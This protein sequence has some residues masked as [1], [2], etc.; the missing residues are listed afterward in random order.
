MESR[1]LPRRFASLVLK[2]G[3][4]FVLRC[5]RSKIM[6]PRVP[7]IPP[8]LPEAFTDEQ[9]AVAG[10]RDNPVA[11]LN[12]TRTLVQHP[13]LLRT[14][15]PFAGYV[16]LQSTLPARERELFVLRIL[17]LCNE[18]YEASH[19]QVIARRL[20]LTDAEIAAAKAGGAGLSSFEQL[21]A[22]AANELVRDHGISEQTWSSLEQRYSPQ[23]MIELIF[24]AGMY[25]VAS[26]VTNSIGVQ[27]EEDVEHAWKPK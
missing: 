8:L 4:T 6:P 5:P 1:Y 22:G 27:P 20:G 13:A 12:L 14:W 21:L 17:A 15:A 16:G 18:T 23:Q 26:L 9:A 7:R 25:I 24:T 2:L 11:A 3:L 10:G 19:H